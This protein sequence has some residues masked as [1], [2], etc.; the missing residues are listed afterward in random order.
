MDRFQIITNKSGK[1]PVYFLVDTL[2]GQKIKE[3]ENRK[4][5][6]NPKTELN[7]WAEL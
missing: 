3:T 4:A 6:E 5:L 2:T 1:F 7:E